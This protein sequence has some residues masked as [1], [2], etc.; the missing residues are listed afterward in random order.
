MLFKLTTSSCKSDM[1]GSSKIILIEVNIIKV[2]IIKIYT[3]N[4][5]AQKNEIFC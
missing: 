5:T 2:I 4:I 3:K 1:S